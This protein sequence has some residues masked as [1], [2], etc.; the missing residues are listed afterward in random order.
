MC[1][2]I[3]FIYQFSLGAYSGHCIDVSVLDIQGTSVNIKSPCS[4]NHVF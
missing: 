3:S 1:Q 2:F 4:M